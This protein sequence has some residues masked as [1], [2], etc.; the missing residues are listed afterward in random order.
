VL[1]RIT[2]RSDMG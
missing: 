1:E 2:P